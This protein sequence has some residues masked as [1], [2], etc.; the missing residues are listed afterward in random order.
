MQ[1]PPINVAIVG[2]GMA[3]RVFHAPYIAATPSLHLAAVVARQ[4][5]AVIPAGAARRG[6]IAAVLA[7][8]AIAVVVI[9]TPSD[10]H[11]ALAA[12]ALRAGKH[13]VAEKPLA[14]S[15]DE[16]RGLARLAQ[17]QERLLV[18]FHNRRWDSDFL[19]V[20]QAIEA[21]RIG[22]VVHF[23]SHFDRFRPQVRDRW[24]E[25]AG[26]G[27]GVWFDLGP[28]LVDQALALFGMPLGV[29]A[30]IAALRDGTGAASADDWAN[31]VLRY[32]DR[33][34]V[35]HAGMCVAGGSPRFIV[36]GTQGTL[37]K[38]SFDPQESQSV[39]GLRPGDADWGIDPDPLQL[40]D[41]TGAETQLPAPRGCQQHFY[42]ALAQA[43]RGEGPPPNSIDELLAVHAVIEAAQISAR[44]GRVVDPSLL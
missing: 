23:E 39:A 33:R 2:N 38:R 42:A 13:V 4:P 27:A 21:G 14:L 20:H 34:V 24:R 29:S 18:A 3:T 6:D 44:E 19:A 9:A 36:H 17:K 26:P 7:D 5:D 43:L 25:Q 1:T 8:P 37:I 28:H 12:Q 16:A 32:P 35:L 41:G 15:L 11:A 22:R 31:V 40:I 10:T 30:D